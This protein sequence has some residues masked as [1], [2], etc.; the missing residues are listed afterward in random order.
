[1][2]MQRLL[3]PL[4][5][6]F[7]FAC[8][9]T[10]PAR[11]T[12][13]N[14]APLVAQV[15]QA[16]EAQRAAAEQFQSAQEQVINLANCESGSLRAMHAAT[17]AEHDDA[18]QAAVAMNSAIDTLAQSADTLFQQWQL[19]TEAL[20]DARLQAESQASLTQS[21][22]SYEGL[23]EAMRQSAAQAD[24][25]LAALNNTV[26]SMQDSLNA[27]AVAARKDQLDALANDIGALV[28]QLNSSI[29]RADEFVA[30]A[31]Q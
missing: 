20:T 8:Q 29:V 14:L 30:S 2:F 28:H 11:P 26:T 24:P 25:V 10:N 5:S 13:P 6:L 27:S 4:L 3:L 22:Q 18:V 16:R 12:Y 23:I 7:L 21:F 19:E 31:Q 17:V 1:M 15:V 9:A